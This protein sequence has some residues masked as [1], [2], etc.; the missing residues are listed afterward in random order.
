MIKFSII[1]PSYLDNERTISLVSKLLTLNSSE[2]I[3]E[4]IIVDNNKKAQISFSV[5]SRVK[6]L[7][8][9]TP[10]SYSARNYGV[11]N[12]Q[13]NYVIFTDS[14]CMPD[15]NWFEKI[16]T[17]VLDG[18]VEVVAGVTKIERGTANKWA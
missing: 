6:V 13:G 11:L 12:S 16:Y 1:V 2:K 14:D 18:N 5:D 17:T 9:E 7:H 8:C 10:G 4:I 15:Q 3:Y